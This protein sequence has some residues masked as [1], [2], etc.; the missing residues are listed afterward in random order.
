MLG[1]PGR[2]GGSVK[3]S[4]LARKSPIRRSVRVTPRLDPAQRAWKQPRYGQCE[5]CGLADPWPLH[6]HHVIA[7]QVLARHGLPQWNAA[8][9]M[10]LCSRCHF[11]HE[12]GMENRR[13]PISRVPVRAVE[14]AVETLGEDVAVL[15]LDRH[16]AKDDE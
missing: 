1:V 3:R 8:N 15:Y 12:Y 7:R 16:Y 10:N 5:N 2:E 14:W 4:P 9:R 13:I 6:G 11:E